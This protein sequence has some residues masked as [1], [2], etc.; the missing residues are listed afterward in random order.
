VSEEARRVI[1]RVRT[2]LEYRGA[3]DLLADLP[4]EMGR[5]QRACSEASDAVL[6]RYF[7]G[8]TATPWVAEVAL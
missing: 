2:G 4:A 3:A 1:G 8:N 7:P 5:I 6:R